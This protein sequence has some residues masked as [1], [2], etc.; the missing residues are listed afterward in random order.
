[1][2]VTELMVSLAF[3]LSVL[4]PESTQ[5]SNSKQKATRK[6]AIDW[7]NLSD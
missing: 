3:L 7:V 2:A 1:M 5:T 4:N 6:P